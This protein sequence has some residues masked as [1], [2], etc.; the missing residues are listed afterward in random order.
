MAGTAGD[1]G[2]LSARLLEPD[3]T[4]LGSSVSTLDVLNSHGHGH[5]H[6]GRT[7]PASSLPAAPTSLPP[8][9]SVIRARSGTVLARGMILKRDY[10]P[11]TLPPA[12]AETVF[13]Q[14]APQFRSLVSDS[15][16]RVFGT[17]QPTEFGIESILT[18]LGSRRPTNVKTTFVSLRAEPLLFL[19]SR[20]FTLR[21]SSAPL[22]NLASYAG[23]SPGR[24]EAL[25]QRLLEDVLEEAERFGGM[26]LVHDEIRDSKVIPTWIAISRATVATPAQLFEKLSKS[27][28]VDYYRLPLSPESAPSASYIDDY[29]RI[30]ERAASDPIVL[31]CGRGVG[32]TTWA[33][34]AVGLVRNRQRSLE[35]GAFGRSMIRPRLPTTIEAGLPDRADSESPRKVGKRR[36]D[37]R[38]R[39]M[40]EEMGNRALLR[41]LYVLEK[42]QRR[43]GGAGQVLFDT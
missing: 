28:E 20:A 12:G 11:K 35:N 17:A 7:A 34:L 32:R 36:A 18:S 42:G 21:M 15:D 19:S 43:Q 25:E 38:E 31:S 24:L 33:M 4:L 3:T 41:V 22:H 37:P 40:E 30:L 23:I 6:A 2:Q 16:L 27:Y 1:V 29:L 8:P 13:F 14:G 5:G 26:L 9:T 10:F 39:P